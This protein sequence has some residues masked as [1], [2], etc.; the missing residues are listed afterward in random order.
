ML[1]QVARFLA[2]GG[3]LLA[4]GDRAFSPEAQRALHLLQGTGCRVQGSGFRVQGSGFRV[5]DSGC[6]VQGSGFTGV[7]RS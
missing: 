7:P 4:E 6:R 3:Q 2:G 5:Q 1:N